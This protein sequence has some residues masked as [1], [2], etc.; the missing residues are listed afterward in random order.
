[1]D[2]VVIYCLQLLDMHLLHSHCQTLVKARGD[3]RKGAKSIMEEASH[4]R[5]LQLITG[6]RAL[7]V[8][9]TCKERDAPAEVLQL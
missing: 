4:T 3:D 2:F 9:W 1:M 5:V 6:S 8:P 7:L